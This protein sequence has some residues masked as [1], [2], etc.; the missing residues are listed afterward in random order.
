MEAERPRGTATTNGAHTGSRRFAFDVGWVLVADAVG[1]ALA[2]AVQ[3]LLARAL[4]ATGYGL[5]SLALTVSG[6]SLLL[7]NFGLG[8]AIVK[9]AADTTQSFEAA[10]RDASSALLASLAFAIV[11]ALAVLL[12][13]FRI[14][15]LLDM[16]ELASLL[17]I[18]ALSLPFASVYASVLGILNGQRRMRKYA[19]LGVGHRVVNAV[20]LLTLIALGFG[21]RGA[22]VGVVATELVLCTAGLYLIRDWLAIRISGCMAAARRLIRFSVFMFGCNAVNAVLNYTDI[23][24][25]GFFL[26]AEDVGHYGAAIAISAVFP[27]IPGAV[28]RITY[29]TASTHH[30][31]GNLHALAEMTRTSMKYSACILL[32]IG[33]ATVL[34]ADDIMRLLFG[35]AFRPA[36]IPLA[37]LVAVRVLRGS[38]VVPSG[39]VLPAVGRPD[40]NL[41][42]EVACV[43]INVCLNML[44]IPSH[45][46]QGA[47][48]ATATALTIGTLMWLR[49]VRRIAG[50]EIDL[51]WYGRALGGAAVVA[52][53][54]YALLPYVQRYLLGS[55]LSLAFGAYV[56]RCLL[57]SQ[58]RR[59]IS[60]LARTVLRRS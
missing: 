41:R 32:P 23:L 47:A 36:A 24:M 56:V 15:A 25:V 35:A 31:E 3:P 11:T 55:L 29:P 10:K 60:S 54:F 9:F 20:F 38:T 22:L 17:A 27:K 14:A 53:A 13:R 37:I 39:Q 19:S 57:S 34:F 16:P 48:M 46:L 6:L 18:L 7:A 45:G 42:I 49:E 28:Q 52:L 59:S 50:I 30:A 5:L 21:I 33:L 26:T 58:D 40:I 43:A 4:G 1:M 12:W 2:F 8:Q 51:N 44:L